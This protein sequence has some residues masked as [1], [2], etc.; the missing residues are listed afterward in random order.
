MSINRID[1]RERRAIQRAF[2]RFLPLLIF[3]FLPF[4]LLLSFRYYNTTK[5]TIISQ[6]Q[7]EVVDAMIDYRNYISYMTSIVRNIESD[8]IELV[9]NDQQ[10]DA[11]EALFVKNMQE[12]P[13][14]GQ[15]RMIDSDGMELIRMDRANGEP[16]AY[17]ASKLQNKSDRYFYQETTLLGKHQFL[18]S[19][20]NLYMENGEIQLDP[21]TGQAIPVLKI[22]SPLETGARRIGYFVVTF[23]M[24]D[25]LNQLRGSLGCAGCY[26]LIADGNGYLFNDADDSNNFGFCY[27]EAYE[28]HFRTVRTLF[29][30]LDLTAA[31]GSLIEGSKI[32]SYT[33]FENIYDRS[34]DY[35]VSEAATDRT[36]FL[37]YY[38]HNSAYADDLQYSYFYHLIA[39]WQTQL[40]SAAGLLLLYMLVILLIFCYDR[41]RFTDLFSDNRYTKVMLK[42]AINHHQF[43]NY[44]QP[45]INIQDGSVL[46]IEALSRWNLHG[47]IL[48]PGMFMEEIQHYRL[49]QALDENVFRCM[50]RDWKVMEKHPEFMGTFISINCCQQTFSSLIK[51]PP[52]TIIRLTEEEKAYVV[53]ELVENIIFNQNTQDRIR[54]MYKNNILFAID[55]FGTGNSNISFIRSLENLKVKIDRT[56][57]P[58]HLDN[59]KERVIIEA[60]VKMFIDQ[61]MRLIVEGV[62][63][64]EQYQY[65]KSLGIVGIQGFYFSKPMM[66]E[67]LIWFMQKRVYTDKLK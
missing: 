58:I 67:D 11:F 18:F 33:A 23:L 45:I 6:Q 43:E 41:T 29:P 15:L 57:V 8:Y 47:Q 24:R 9:A 54:E 56:F 30:G 66:L 40:L 42:K 61:G 51:D 53:L 38:D 50:R 20:L 31:N 48:D 32:C 63:T 17:P 14:I 25:Y 46:G 60:F 22:S 26:V 39:S 52:A 35:F 28:Q 3:L 10:P 59:S 64:Q 65:L 16:Y 13:I 27:S 21:A 2:F 62:E 49:G 36:I 7:S 55:D 12:Y 1:T 5:Q 34:K 37:V 44:Y 4:S 19:V